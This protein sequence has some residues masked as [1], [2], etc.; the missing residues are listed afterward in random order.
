MTKKNIDKGQ[1]WIIVF[2][3]VPVVLFMNLGKYFTNDSGMQIL[4]GGLFGGMGGLVGFGLNQIVKNKS[5]LIKGLTI[6]VFL[7]VSLVTIRLI[8]L[9]Y[10]N[11]ESILTEEKKLITCPVCGYKTLTKNDKFC[12]E[13]LIEL[14]ESEMTEEGYSSIEEFINE[15]QIVFFCPDSIVNDIDFYNPKTSEDGYEKDLD[16]KPT[17]PKD[18]ILKFNKEY[19]EYIKENP[20]K[21]TIKADS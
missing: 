8:H 7:I 10:S 4:Y 1:I 2:A 15:E 12:G 19:V 21:I 13:C 5:T 9:N 11:T 18:S 16:W 6:G 3:V 17:A 14:T 20:I